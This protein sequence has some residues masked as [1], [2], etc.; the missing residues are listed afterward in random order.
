MKIISIIA[1]VTLLLAVP[2]AAQDKPGGKPS[3][4]ASTRSSKPPANDQKGP[5]Q[6]RR[7]SSTSK[8]AAVP[9]D[10]LPP[11]LGVCLIGDNYGYIDDLADAEKCDAVMWVN[12]VAWADNQRRLI[13]QSTL[14]GDGSIAADGTTICRSCSGTCQTVSLPIEDSEYD[15]VETDGG[16]SPSECLTSIRQ[17]C[18]AGSY[19]HLASARCGN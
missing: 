3:R 7:L 12:T 16:Q 11:G 19:R 6:P 13:D 5:M 17:I 18:E 15:D 1:L 2:A 4:G 14:A 10:K 8:R 9:P